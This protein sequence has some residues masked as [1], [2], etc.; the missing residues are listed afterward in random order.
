MVFYPFN[1]NLGDNNMQTIKNHNELYKA[2]Q[3]AV[4]EIKQDHNIGWVHIDHI[5]RVVE[6]K[7]PNRWGAST[8]LRRINEM[9]RFNLLIK[10]PR[11]NGLY[12][13]KI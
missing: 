10:N 8:I 7:H 12:D 11:F 6:S 1:N 5:R 4:L 3:L 9:P 2:I 13:L